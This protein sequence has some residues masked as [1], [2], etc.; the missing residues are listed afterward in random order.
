MK[1]NISLWTFG[2]ALGML[3]ATALGIYYDGLFILIWVVSLSLAILIAIGYKTWIHL[4]PAGGFANHV[5]F[6]RFVL[7]L[8][9]LAMHSVLSPGVFVTMI[10]AVIIADGF[11]GYLARKF[12]QETDFGEVFD[13][14]VD[15]FLALALTFLIWMN[16]QTAGWVL[17]AG[18]LRYIFIIVYRL[19][20][21][22]DKK[23]PSMPKTKV[24]AVI[25]FISLLIPMILEWETAI[26]IVGAGCALVTYSFL[27]EF[28]LIGRV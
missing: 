10:V 19:I 18:F 1:Q 9:A 16:H 4:H 14:E 6:F 25:F 28:Y 15:A 23:R 2:H 3:S 20:G 21:W 5:T 12:K 17:A 7:L 27:R 24:I 8:V 11:D 26:W 22:H 13:T